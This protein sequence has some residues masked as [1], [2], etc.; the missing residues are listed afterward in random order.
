MGRDRAMRAREKKAEQDTITCHCGRSPKRCPYAQR[1][2]MPYGASE[3]HPTALCP[4]EAA[5]RLEEEANRGRRGG[6]HGRH[7]VARASR[8]ALEDIWSALR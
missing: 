5:W 6:S 8:E 3:Y 2:R 1:I 4:L 7:R